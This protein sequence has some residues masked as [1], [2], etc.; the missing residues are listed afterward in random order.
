VN[1]GVEN[2]KRIAL[3][4]LVGLLMV[5]CSQPKPSL[6]PAP[7]LA[8]KADTP[9]TIPTS[10]QPQEYKPTEKH[11]QALRFI[12]EEDYVA[13]EAALQQVVVAEPGAAEAWNDLSLVQYKLGRYRDAA[14][15]AEQAL[16][17]N[18]GFVF[19]EYNLGLAHLQ[20]GGINA[21]THLEASAKAQPDRPEPWYALGLAYKLQGKL[22]EA[23]AAFQKAGNY[24]P[25][26]S[27]LRT[28]ESDI[29]TWAWNLQTSG[30]FPHAPKELFWKLNSAYVP[31]GYERIIEQ[32]VP[33]RLRKMGETQWAALVRDESS[34]DTKRSI[35]FRA[36]TP[37]DDNL[38]SCSVPGPAPVNLLV[39]DQTAGQ[40]LAISAGGKTTICALEDRGV[41]EVFT[42]TGSVTVTS[43]EMRVDGTLH[44][45]VPELS[46][47]LPYADARFAAE[48]IQEIHGAG[49]TMQP[50][51]VISA[52]LDFGE[53]FAWHE[54]VAL[55]PY[56]GGPT[57]IYSFKESSP[58]RVTYPFPNRVGALS[59]PGHDFLAVVTLMPGGPNGAD[60]L[61]LEH[62]QS[63]NTLR[64]VFSATSDGA[65]FDD[66]HVSTVTKRYLPQGGTQAYETVYIW[67]E[68]K[69]TFVPGKTSEFKP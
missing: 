61:V 30:R 50:G 34:T 65:G 58:H 21:V 44:L 59:V 66:T 15:S 33:I 55:R 67:D 39:F 6:S 14:A 43:K 12:G 36:M 41:D 54:G 27:A 22:T 46:T 20:G 3:V 48:I 47:Y 42:T 23:T 28:L 62:N 29:K 63:T 40:H 13:A 37:T 10:Q 49:Y 17:L 51:S 64:S 68:A 8:P 24:G 25:A 45:F 4:L 16:T 53:A 9:A 11:Q 1:V 5:A 52:S 18:P 19:A 35:E 38:G 7:V 31:H 32:V 60:V 56:A 26:R 2:V 57:A 69:Y